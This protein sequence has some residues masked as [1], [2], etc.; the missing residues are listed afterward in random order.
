MATISCNVSGLKHWN[1]G[2]LPSDSGWNTPDD[3]SSGYGGESY[4]AVYKFSIP[5]LDS[6]AL[7]TATLTF[8]LPWIDVGYASSFDVRYYLTKTAPSS[9]SSAVQGD[10]IVSGS[11]SDSGTGS[12]QWKTKTFT[13]GSFNATADTYYLYLTDGSMAAEFGGQLTATCTY[14]LRT[15]T[16]KYNSNGGSGTMADT[17]VTYGTSTKVR[18]NTF[19]KSGYR[20]KCW[21][22]H[23]QSDNLWYYTN[24]NTNNWYAKDN[25]PSGY[26]LYEWADQGSASKTTSIHNDVIT[27]YAQWEIN[28][29]TVKYNA[30]GGSN[31]P[32]S[33]IK[34]YGVVLTLSSTKPIRDGYTFKGWGTS[35]TDT[36]VDY[37]AGDYYTANAGII[38]YAIW[39]ASG[40]LRI[41]DVMYAP[42]VYRNGEWVRAVPYS[43]VNGEWKI[44]A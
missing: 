33:Q 32:S 13:T 18:A 20:F 10:V 40:I 3:T 37:A 30:N 42:Y 11:I 15:F 1:G 24:G 38:L 39:E 2:W 25:Q 22:V 41:G 35:A 23:R 31:A 28:T 7:G 6:G 44:G 4:T 21:H 8:N 14:S 43:Y 5:D 26:I 17:V 29:Y 19:T 16:I 36:S 12:L 9:S 34:T 27:M